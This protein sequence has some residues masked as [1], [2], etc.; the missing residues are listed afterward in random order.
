MTVTGVRWMLSAGSLRSGVLLGLVRVG[1][2]LLVGVVGCF[3]VVGVLGVPAL[4]EGTWTATGSLN[5]ARAGHTATLSSG[6]KVLVAGG[7][8]PSFPVLA[9]AELYDPASGTWNATGSLNTA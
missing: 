7:V 1:V 9:S 2:R 3:L 8:G 6:G 4:A 5:T